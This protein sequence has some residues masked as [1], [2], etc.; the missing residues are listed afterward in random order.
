[1]EL[2]FPAAGRGR[3][4]RGLVEAFGPP[5]FTG[6]NGDNYLLSCLG[7]QSAPRPDSPALRLEAARVIVTARA[8]AGPS[9]SSRATSPGAGL[10]GSGDRLRPLHAGTLLDASG[11]AE[12]RLSGVG[13]GDLEGAGGGD[14]VSSAGRR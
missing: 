12:L 5:L 7:E 9:T 14:R 1:M 4:V 13:A 11:E 10:R 6:R 2:D 8:A 3:D